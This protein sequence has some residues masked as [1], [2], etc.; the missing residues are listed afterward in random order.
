MAH[1][2]LFPAD[3]TSWICLHLHTGVGPGF[4]DIS[5]RISVPVQG[6]VAH[7]SQVP[8]ELYFSTFKYKHR[9]SELADI[10]IFAFVFSQACLRMSNS[11]QDTRTTQREYVR[12]GWFF[13]F[14]NT[15]PS[16]WGA[17][18]NHPLEFLT[19]DLNHQPFLPRSFLKSLLL[20]M[21]RAMSGPWHYIA[22]EPGS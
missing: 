5:E 11:S 15:G 1:G 10:L 20:H 4:S 13:F 14:S 9:S 19:I 3:R 6:S 17:H 12:K 2:R 8:M 22:Q 18:H 16:Y 7:R 21:F